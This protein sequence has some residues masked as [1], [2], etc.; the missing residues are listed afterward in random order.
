[1]NFYFDEPIWLISQF[2]AF[3]AFI[4]SIWSF[5]V[6]NKVKMLFL[7]GTF[8]IN[9][10][11]SATLLE[12]YSL[13]ALFGLAAIRNFVFCYLDWRVSVGKHVPRWLSYVFAGI[14]AAAT[15]TGTTLLWH[16][17]MAL[18]LEVLICVTL[19]GL[20]W[21]NIQKGTNLM[22]ISFI[23]NR[24][25]NII[26]HVYFNNVIAVIIAASAITSNLVFY[27]REYIAYKKKKASSQENPL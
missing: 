10:A 13:G 5:Q 26:N 3:I 15:I 18:W 21:G 20:I 6:K 23:A 17:G 27:L 9:L 22:R 19:L 2:F 7:I 4:F 14:F 8:S 11:I 12:N 25:F 1:M 16:T 24:T